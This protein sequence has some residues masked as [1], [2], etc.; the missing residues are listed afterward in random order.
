MQKPHP[1][2]NLRLLL[3]FIFLLNKFL[4]DSAFGIVLYA[5]AIQNLIAV[6]AFLKNRIPLLFELWKILCREP[7]KSD[8]VSR[9]CH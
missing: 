1:F 6:S 4:W 7:S 9:R 5:V 8:P 3:R 2:P